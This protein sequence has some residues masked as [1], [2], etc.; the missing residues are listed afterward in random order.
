MPL[1]VGDRLGPYEITG[2]L[3]AGGMGIVLRA[4]DTK[5]DRDVALKVLPEAFTSDPD[6][7]A[8]FEREAKV[9]ASLNHP[10]IGSIYG[11]EEA[12]GV[13]A[14]V[15]E[16]VEGP[17]L[18]DRIKQGP[19]P[20]DEALPIA[21]QIA[22]ALEAAHEQGVI[23]RDLKPAN[24]KVKADGTVKVLDFGLAKAFQPDAGDTSLS[25]SPTISLTAAA[26]QMGMVIGTAA[27]MS[28][29]QA[30]G[31][32]VDK[33][34]DV[35]AFG[36]VLYEMLAGQR[37]FSGKD[38]SHTLAYVLTKD[39]DWAA[40]STDTPDTLRRLL[41]RCLERDPRKRMRDIGEARIELEAPPA[42][43]ASKP[44]AAV[45]DAVSRLQVWQRPV[46]LVLGVVALV[47][48]TGAA[49]WNLMRPAPRPVARALLT[50]PPS[51]PLEGARL[52]VKVA[53]TPDGTRVVYRGLLDG[54]SRLFVRTLAEFDATPLTG[55]SANPRNP[56]ISPDGNW[57]GFFDG[58]RAL[59]RVSIRG[60]PPVTI[61]A[62]DGSGPL[63]ASW[64]TDDRIIFA[65]NAV[66]SGLLRVPMGG[67]EVEVLTTPDS[68]RGE[69]DH[70]WPEILP[71]GKAVLFTIRTMGPI[72]NAQIAVLSLDSGE[73][74]VLFPGGS[75]PRYVPTG[76]IVYGVGGR[77]R[78]VGFDLNSLT[79]T[80]E[81]IPI[82][83]DVLMGPRGEANFAVA[84]DG[85]L[86]YVRG[87]GVEVLGSTLVWVDREGREEPLAAERAPYMEPRVS[88]DGTRLATRVSD[89]DGG[90][91]IYIYDIARNNFTQLTF[92]AELEC[93]PVWTP[94]GERVVF[95]S[96]RDG[97]PNLYV[98]SADG[99]GE[100]E[101]LTE[102]DDVQ[103]GSTWSADGETLVLESAGDVHTWSFDGAPTSTALFQTEFDEQAS[104]VSPDGRW[105]AYDSDEDGDRDVYVRP[106]PDVDGGKW[107]V[108]TQGGAN[109]VWSPDGRELFY[110]SGNAM[111]VAPITSTPSFDVGN[112]AVVFEGNYIFAGF[113][114]G[115][116]LSSDGTR[117]LMRKSSGAQADDTPASL[118]LVVVFNWFEELKR[119]VPV[120]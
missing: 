4:R 45:V 25:A 117:F 114:P 61:A 55:L 57:V 12:E 11:L 97:T 54:Q 80:S 5:L 70:T 23:H 93:C 21:K 30:S 111:M 86:V 84:R 28:P 90:S 41:R 118:D 1:N 110:I 24:I 99:T 36:V 98:K 43:P 13:K 85:S 109:P 71:G 79:V 9:L 68:E 92:S 2:E 105:I 88:P 3:G 83:D 40:L 59:Q 37:L 56:F 94:D 60:G 65:T 14:L 7:L 34:V 69:L 8:R 107:K 115:F 75:N 18:A 22:E 47:A 78:A 49:V 16:L 106:F 52:D 116:D 108:S 102:S 120:P 72:E 39:I 31:N 73:Y 89:I 101:R 63:G 81:P 20:I 82:V 44:A 46:P 26:T 27:Y 62:I 87:G 6:R 38:V 91:D 33:R 100:V 66:V 96:T 35:W 10:N 77:L 17:T 51:V 103:I 53:L 76:H 50:P 119:L 104:S 113:S 19:I 32:A 29:E 15:L 42:P 64:G 95:S 67:G 48:I 74:E 58:G 112:P